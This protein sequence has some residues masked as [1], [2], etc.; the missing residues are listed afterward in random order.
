MQI[1]LSTMWSLKYKSM[2]EFFKDARDFGFTHLELSTALTPEKLKE[3]QAVEGLEISSVHAP[4]PNAMTKE[5]L[6]STLS[7]S[8][9]DED[10]RQM[11][12][13]MVKSTVDLAVEMGVRVVIV[14]AGY[15]TINPEMEKDLRKLYKNG[16]VDSSE[17][18]ELKRQLVDIRQFLVCPHVDAAKESLLELAGYARERG[19]QLALENRVN[20]REIPNLDEML[21][22]LSEFNPEVVGYW[23]DVGHAAIQSLTG[24]TPHEEW[25]MALADRMIGVHLHDVRGL[26]DHCA[27]GIGD[28]DW[29]FI[30]RNLPEG[31]VK[32]C[33]IGEWNS[34]EDT[35]K[36]VAFLKDK[37]I[38]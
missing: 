2:A 16:G 28:L 35:R 1:S 22:I 9:C 3:I 29:D 17:F 27:P 33:E 15:A 7:L 32:V 38:I 30:A 18:A 10:E 37:G 23:H 4:C 19:V 21:D 24:F 6:A 5:G 13:R 26:Q 11:A 36:V 8:S 12:V 14:H 20:Y 34:P 25:S 31:I